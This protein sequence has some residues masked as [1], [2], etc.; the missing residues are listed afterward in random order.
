[1]ENPPAGILKTTNK[2]RKFVT[3]ITL[4]PVCECL[5]VWGIKTALITE[6]SK[7]A[8]KVL[9]ILSLYSTTSLENLK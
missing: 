3:I 9:K 4:D 8:I 6:Y 5:K 7:K 2:I 1:M